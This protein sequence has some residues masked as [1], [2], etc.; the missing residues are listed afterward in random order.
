LLLYFFVLFCL[1]VLRNV[2]VIWFMMEVMFLLFLVY[3]IRRE[4]KDAGLVIYFFFQSVVSLILFISLLV[5]VD[6]ILFLL[7]RAKLG[8]FPFFYWIVIVR[9]KVRLL[10][11]LFIMRLQKIRVFWMLWLV[12][13]AS[14]RFIYILSYLRIFFVIVNLILIRDLWLLLVY[15]SIANTGIIVLGIFGDK[16][17]FIIF[18]YLVMIFLIIYLILKLDSYIELLLLV[19]FFM[20]IPPFVLFFMKF[21]FFVRLDFG[22]KIGLVFVVFDVFVL[23]YYFRIV[24]IKFLLMDLGV[25]VY[26]LNIFL[27]CLILFFRNCVALIVFY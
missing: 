25:I 13:K 4:I 7:L 8:L 20:V 3:V 24:F 2:Y 23:I 15:S 6:K 10:G 22:L 5:G 19:F 12:M 9:V 26:L 11:N 1:L 17:M 27:V 21:F 14:L 18:L 16:Y